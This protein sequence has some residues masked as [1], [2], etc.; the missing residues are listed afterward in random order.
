[1]VCSVPSAVFTTTVFAPLSTVFT[2]ATTAL[3]T[4]SAASAAKAQRE[5]SNP[6]IVYLRIVIYLESQYNF[7]SCLSRPR[8][9]AGART[10]DQVRPDG[11]HVELVKFPVAPVFWRTD[12]EHIYVAQVGLDLRENFGGLAAGICKGQP[13]GFLRQALHTVAHSL[14]NRRANGEITRRIRILDRIH[15]HPG[16]LSHFDQIGQADIAARVHAVGENDDC[17]APG[18]GS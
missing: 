7:T 11:A 8:P 15:H 10:D 17:L 6:A 3:A 1:M 2:V 4:S 14:R 16:R 13:S 12:A 18:N 5:N 9:I